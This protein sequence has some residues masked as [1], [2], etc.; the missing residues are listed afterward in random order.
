MALSMS[1]LHALRSVADTGSFAA[2]ARQ[3]GVTQPSVSQLVRK[4][5]ATYNVR[6][7]ARQNG[8]LVATPFCDRV[9]DAA[10]RVLHEHQA[11]ERMLERHGS[12]AKGGLSIGLGNAMPGMAAIAAY[13]KAYPEVKLSVSTG[14]HRQIMRAV[15]EHRV[16]VGILPDVANDRRLRCKTVLTNRVVA[17]LARDHALATKDSISSCE[18]VRQPLIFRSEGSSTQKVVDRYFR[19]RNEKPAPFLTLDTRDGVYEAVLNGMGIGFVWETSS[20]RN[21]SVRQLSLRG[22]GTDSNEVIFAP[23]DRKMETVEAFF[24]LADRD[25]FQKPPSA[26]A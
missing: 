14:S 12:L 18:L 6:L 24:A 7:F 23:A 2:A 17:I 9:C 20:R 8:Q 10:D 16:D 19:L 26:L 3:L 11:L 5:E 21:E 25:L 15:L 13:N 22:G 1:A 4:L